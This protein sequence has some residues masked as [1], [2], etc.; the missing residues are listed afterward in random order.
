MFWKCAYCFS[1]NILLIT[2]TYEPWVVLLKYFGQQGCH[3]GHN[4]GSTPQSNGPGEEGKWS[5][6]LD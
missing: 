1:V 5:R 4:E 6:H 2:H 3:Y